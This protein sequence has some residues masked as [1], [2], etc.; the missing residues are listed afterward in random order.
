VVAAGQKVRVLGRR[1]EY[2]GK[3]QIIFQARDIQLVFEAVDNVDLISID[4]TV[5]R[6]VPLASMAAVVT[7]FWIQS[8]QVTLSWQQLEDTQWREFLGS[9]NKSPN[10]AI[11]EVTFVPRLKTFLHSNVYKIQ[12]IEVAK[13]LLGQLTDRAGFDDLFDVVFPAESD[14][15]LSDMKDVL[16]TL[17]R[18]DIAIQIA[19]NPTDQTFQTSQIPTSFYPWGPCNTDITDQE[20]LD[21]LKNYPGKDK[22]I[23]ARRD[24]KATADEE[25]DVTRRILLIVR[26]TLVKNKETDINLN[27]VHLNGGNC[28]GIDFS[29]IDV[30]GAGFDNCDFTGAIF[31]PIRYENVTPSNSNWWDAAKISKEVLEIFISKYYPGNF[32]HQVIQAHKNFSQEYYVDRIARIALTGN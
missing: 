30:T 10:T 16:K 8:N 9:I 26:T 14:I 25:Y 4:V 29:R 2:R 18:T 27:G 19:C 1:G 5:E 11:S 22:V 17:Q 32:D 15:S 20:A 3:S 6:V 23:Q 24:S 7:T 12:V 31:T 28:T 21:Y 13:R